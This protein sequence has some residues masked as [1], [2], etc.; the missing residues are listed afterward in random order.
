[1]TF[2]SYK[3]MNRSTSVLNETYF[4]QWVDPDLGN[5]Q[6]DYVDVMIRIRYCYNGDADDDGTAGYN[7]DSDDSPAIGVDFF[8]GPLLILVMVLIMMVMANRR[9][10]EQ[11]IMSKFVYYNN[12]FSDFGNPENATHYYGYL[13]EY[14]NGQPMTYGGPG[15]NHQTQNVISCFLDTDPSFNGGQKLLQGMIL[16][17][18]D[19]YSL[20][21]HLH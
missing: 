9:E 11:I 4:G 1:M 20:L 7:Y 6:D 21:V 16:L 5:Y 18:E 10:G 13:R 14:E 12:D 8:R 19:F 17:I 2:Y 15:W 3:I